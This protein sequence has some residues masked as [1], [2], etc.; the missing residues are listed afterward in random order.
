MD[1][2]SLCSSLRGALHAAFLTSCWI[3]G[4]VFD[5]SLAHDTSAEARQIQLGIF[6]AMTPSQRV[7]IAIQ[8]SE[9][10]MAMSETGRRSR[11]NGE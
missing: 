3:N 11:R 2:S 8:M 7:T 9:D 4:E 10:L 5:M 6:R 1:R